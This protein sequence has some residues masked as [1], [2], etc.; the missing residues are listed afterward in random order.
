MLRPICLGLSE[1]SRNLI[2]GL[3][4]DASGVPKVQGFMLSMSQYLCRRLT[5]LARYKIYLFLPGP[6]RSLKI[7]SESAKICTFSTKFGHLLKKPHLRPAPPCRAYRTTCKY[8]AYISSNKT[9]TIGPS[10]SVKIWQIETGHMTNSIW[11]EVVDCKH[12]SFRLK[13]VR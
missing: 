9:T 12:E 2:W 11:V 5:R 4:W 10:K 7:I 8:L 6:V 1:P 13:M 3:R